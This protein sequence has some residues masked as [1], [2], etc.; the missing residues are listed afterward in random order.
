MPQRGVAAHRRTAAACHRSLP[1]VGAQGGALMDVVEAGWNSQ[2]GL[3]VNSSRGIL[4]AS[5][6]ADFAEKARD[7]ALKL[8][9]DMKDI[10]QKK[11]NG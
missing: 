2:C 6:G 11:T 5:S 10:L 1:G 8:R 7:S 9:N 4:Y 3:L